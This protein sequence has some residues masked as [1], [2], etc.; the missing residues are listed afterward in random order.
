MCND[1]DWKRQ[2]NQE[3]CVNNS[4]R[5]ADYARH[6]PTGHWTFL[7]PG[8][9][10][11]WYATLAYKLNGAWNHVAEEMMTSFE[12]GRHQVFRGTSLLSRRA[13]KYKG[14]GK[15]SPHYRAELQ[16]AELVLR[17]IVALN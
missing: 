11:K 13:L 3:V 16:T 10:N 6:F 8:C 17:T 5:V 2:G 15:T 4:S 14:G 7:G 1:I 9:E 12:Q